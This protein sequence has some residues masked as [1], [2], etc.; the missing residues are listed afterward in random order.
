MLYNDGYECRVFR[1][2]AGTLNILGEHN[3]C[4]VN[5]MLSHYMP[6]N[7]RPGKAIVKLTEKDLDTVLDGY[8]RESQ[9]GT[10]RG[11]KDDWNKGKQKVLEHAKENK[12]ARERP[13]RD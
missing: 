7:P 11:S 4:M 8:T 1:P 9:V 12:V 5:M 10:L 3:T 2:V 6:N 13:K